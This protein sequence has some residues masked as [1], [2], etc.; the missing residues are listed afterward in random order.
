VECIGYGSTDS[1]ILGSFCGVDLGY[2]T[3][4]CII[5]FALNQDASALDTLN[6]D[7]GVEGL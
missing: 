3:I 2:L 7:D 5:D 6:T 1:V 4:V